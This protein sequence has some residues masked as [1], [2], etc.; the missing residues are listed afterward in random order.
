LRLVLILDG[1][2]VPADRL[3]MMGWETPVETPRDE[4]GR[5]SKKP[6][7]SHPHQN[8]DRSAAPRNRNPT[9]I[10]IRPCTS[11]R[12]PWPRRGASTTS[13]S[14]RSPEELH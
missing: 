7:R 10:A 4:L 11:R 2:Y 5:P 8:P 9:M 14:W 1:Q 13:T 6:P 12:S 3:R